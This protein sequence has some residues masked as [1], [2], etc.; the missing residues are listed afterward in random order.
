VPI[1]D[2]EIVGATSVPPATTQRLADAIGDA[3]S[4][5]PGGTWVRVRSLDESL[6]AE[7]GGVPDHVRPV[8]VTVLER[9]RPV[10]DAL[11]TKVARVTAAVAAV[12][13]RP[14]DNVHVLFEE[15]AAGRLAFGGRLVARD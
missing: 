10:G 5:R 15:D 2:V 9:V 3:L 6:Y 12:I 4:S 8:F 14:D 11:E 1:V 7:N 13:G